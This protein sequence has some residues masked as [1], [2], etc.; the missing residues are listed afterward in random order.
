MGAQGDGTSLLLTLTGVP[1]WV[2]RPVQLYTY[3]YAGTCASHDEPPAF[4]LNEIV[5]AG[6][7]SN[8][9]PTTGPFTLPKRVPVPMSALLMHPHALVVRTSPADGN[10]DIF[11]GDIK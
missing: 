3:V 10:V 2:S 11:C 5:Q 4:A 9:S 1:P 6:L 8:N 7:F